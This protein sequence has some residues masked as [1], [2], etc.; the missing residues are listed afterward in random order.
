[1]P[2]SGVSALSSC[3]G[4]EEMTLSLRRIYADGRDWSEGLKA[5][6]RLPASPRIDN[7]GAGASSGMKGELI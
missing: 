7:L 2:M 1:M 6:E 5:G 3:S 4:N